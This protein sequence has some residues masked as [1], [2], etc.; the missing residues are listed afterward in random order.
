[1]KEKGR[2]MREQHFAVPTREPPSS[3]SRGREPDPA[4][5]SSAFRSLT[6]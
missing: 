4:G 2:R 5:S 6:F 1:M 3:E